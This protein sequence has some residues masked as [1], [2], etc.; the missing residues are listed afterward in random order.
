MT[1]SIQRWKNQTCS[2]TV[3]SLG[4]SFTESE[5]ALEDASVFIKQAFM[6]QTIPAEANYLGRCGTQLLE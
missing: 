2:V 5:W 4:L 1:L 3:Y 6:D